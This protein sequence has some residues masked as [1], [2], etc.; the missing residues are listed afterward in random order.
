[1]APGDQFIPETGFIGSLRAF[2]QNQKVPAIIVFFT[3]YEMAIY[4]LRYVLPYADKLGALSREGLPKERRRDF[5]DAGHLLDDVH[6]TLRRHKKEVKKRLTV[7]ARADLEERLSALSRVMSDSPFDVS[8]FDSAR[9]AA[10]AAVDTHLAPW[11]RSEIRE[12]SESILIAV[13]VALLLRAFVVEAFQI[14]SGSMLPTLQI[15]DHIF[16]NKFIYGAQVPFTRTRVLSSLPPQRGDVLVFEYPD[17]NPRNE[18]VDY[19]KRVI[20]LPGDT[21]IVRGGHPV[22]NGWE[23]PHCRVGTYRFGQEIGD[24]Q[25]AELFVEFLGENSYLTLFQG[26]RSELK[27][28]PYRVKEGEF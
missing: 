13:G 27:E 19:I 26:G 28:G 24:P 2:A 9:E 5:E 3:I 20:A 25:E 4:Q 21:L 17:P 12:Y 7:A 22:I 11:R 18:R 10:H 14:P 16:V 6:W 15:K 1:M 23:V 8:S